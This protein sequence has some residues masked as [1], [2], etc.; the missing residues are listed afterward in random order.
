M[1]AAGGNALAGIADEMMAN[2]GYLENVLDKALAQLGSEHFPKHTAIIAADSYMP[3]QSGED[4]KGTA[5]ISRCDLAQRVSG[6]A[7]IGVGFYSLSGIALVE[8]FGFVHLG[9]EVQPV[10]NHLLIG[11]EEL[12]IGVAIFVMNNSA[13]L[14]KT[15]VERGLRQS[16]EYV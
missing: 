1:Y 11:F 8:R 4:R 16:V 13:G 3:D 5:E 12:D 10:A 14:L 9:N 7:P 2:Q 15:I 6:T